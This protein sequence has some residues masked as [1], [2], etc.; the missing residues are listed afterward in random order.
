MPVLALHA[1]YCIVQ[2]CGPW[3]I[4]CDNAVQQHQIR[5]FQQSIITHQSLSLSDL[6]L[7]EL[8]KVCPAGLVS[9]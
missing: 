6:K 8:L 5:P 7:K 2:H 3:Q 1:L 9:H 4:M